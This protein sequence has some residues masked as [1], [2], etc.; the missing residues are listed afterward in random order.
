MD[1]EED[2]EEEDDEE[3]AAPPPRKDRLAAAVD[4]EAFKDPDP[5]AAVLEAMLLGATYD[6]G[7]TFTV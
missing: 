1:V 3:E 4:D 6:R 5:D 7:F 2:A